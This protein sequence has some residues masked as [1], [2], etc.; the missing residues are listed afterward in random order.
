MAM[1]RILTT[2]EKP[3]MMPPSQDK[4]HTMIGDFAIIAVSNSDNEL[5]LV[6]TT[7]TRSMV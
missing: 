5:Y 4:A 7:S 3:P 6:T 1:A 2:K